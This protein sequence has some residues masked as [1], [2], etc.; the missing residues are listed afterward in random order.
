KSGP[1]GQWPDFDTP[2]AITGN[3]SQKSGALLHPHLPCVTLMTYVNCELNR[4]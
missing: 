4:R 2:R 1:S 3:P